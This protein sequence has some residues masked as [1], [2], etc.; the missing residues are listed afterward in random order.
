MNGKSLWYHFQ[1]RFKA[2]EDLDC[3]FR[4][5]GPDFWFNLCIV[6]VWVY[7]CIANCTNHIL[8]IISPESFFPSI[9]V[10]WTWVSQVIQRG[11]TAS[12][13]STDFSSWN[14]YHLGEKGLELCRRDLIHLWGKGLCWNSQT[15]HCLYLETQI[16]EVYNLLHLQTEKS[17]SGLWE[18]LFGFTK[19]SSNKS[20]KGTGLWVF[21]NIVYY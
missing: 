1:R 10:M 8:V 4:N 20:Q 17:E 14:I 19:Y 5:V 3:F 9:S 16:H 2:W 21:I 7:E 6:C 13:I 15:A 18:T 12:L 11:F